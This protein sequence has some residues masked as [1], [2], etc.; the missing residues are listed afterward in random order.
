MRTIS[1]AATR[2][3]YYVQVIDGGRPIFEYTAG[4]SQHDSQAFIAPDSAGAVSHSQVRRWA[5]Q[6]AEEMAEELMANRG[7]Y[8]PDL[9]AQL[10]PCE[11]VR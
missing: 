11:A 5:R 7:E 6:T 4:N 3:G 10:E 2:Y 8:D 9:E 1:Y